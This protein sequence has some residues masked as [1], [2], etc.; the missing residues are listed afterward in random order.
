[1]P[2][3][4]LRYNHTMKRALLHAAALSIMPFLASATVQACGPRDEIA[5]YEEDGGDVFEV[6]NKSQEPWSVTGLLLSL[7]GSRGR[8]VFDTAD[9]GIGTSMYRPFSAVPS[10][11]GFAGASPVDDGAEVIALKFSDF[12][13]GKIFRFIIDVDDRLNEGSYGQATVSDAEIEGA[14][15][16]AEM[17][18][19]GSEKIRATGA[20]GREG[21]AVIGD[22]GLC[23]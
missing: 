5:F 1:M 17:V 14:T 23:A 15:A 16:E 11:V 12:G 18:R 21:R 8:L 19:A 4:A 7:S 13:P 22:G 2:P 3:L 10:D 6:S 9:G 20:F